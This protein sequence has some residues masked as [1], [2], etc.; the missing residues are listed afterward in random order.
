M[1]LNQPALGTLPYDATDNE[2]RKQARA[3]IE[4]DPEFGKEFVERYKTDLE[5]SF[6]QAEATG[7]D[8]FTFAPNIAHM[9]RSV[10]FKEEVARHNIATGAAIDVSALDPK[11]V[12]RLGNAPGDDPL[13]PEAVAEWVTTRWGKEMYPELSPKEVLAKY[14]ELTKLPDAASIEAPKGFS[15]K[16]Y[17]TA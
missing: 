3:L 15:S 14:A 1:S 10:H 11:V 12:R 9:V 2:R 8:P 17:K 6:A 7:N 13:T 4:S 5:A 16:P